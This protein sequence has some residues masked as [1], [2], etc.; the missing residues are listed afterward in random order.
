MSFLKTISLAGIQYEGDIRAL[1][2]KNGKCLVAMPQENGNTGKVVLVDIVS[3]SVLWTKTGSTANTL[4]LFGRGVVALT[5]TH[6]GVHHHEGAN[7]LS[8]GGVTIYDIDGAELWNIAGSGS[9]NLGGSGIALNSTHFAYNVDSGTSGQ[10]VVRSL[11]T[12]EITAT[13]ATPSGVSSGYLAV[14]GGSGYASL[15]LGETH[16]VAS[17]YNQVSNV[18]G[19]D[20]KGV[21]YVWDLAGNL[22]NTFFS[23]STSA[24]MGG[25]HFAS[26]G[27]AVEND[28][29][30]TSQWRQDVGANMPSTTT[31]DAIH[32]YS[33]SA[34]SH[35]HTA[36][37]SDSDST[38]T[39]QTW[40]SLV[41][42]NEGVAGATFDD[43]SPYQVQTFILGLREAEP[44][45][46]L[47]A[48]SIATTA[49]VA[50]AANSGPQG[51]QGDIGLQGATG[52]Q[53][54]AGSDGAQGPIGLQGA[55]GPQGAQ[56]ANVSSIDELTDVD[57]TT[58]APTANQVLVWDN[59]NSKFVPGDAASGGSSV[60]VSDSAPSNPSSGDL[61][62]NSTNMKLYAYYVDGSSNQWVEVSASSGGGITFS[63]ATSDVTM[64]S[65][66]TYILDTST[67][68][69]A[70]LPASAVLGDKIGIIDGTGGASSNNITVARNS[71]KIQG[72]SENMT[73]AK[74][75]AAFELVYYNA[76]NGW[77]LTSV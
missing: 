60:T 67:A 39:N 61:W 33:I 42:Y 14:A 3:E 53:G 43:R 65:G 37:F 29:V 68:I 46:Y 30:V 70:T 22:T 12:G 47:P 13:L 17:D 72:L 34:N 62:L 31:S 71:H 2:V 15:D 23:P 36:T 10:I 9:Q 50:A 11:A 49:F 20:Y 55:T 66:Y 7:G 56:G 75:R 27:V 16:I 54:T 64:L 6:A 59:A 38:T 77:L 18:D 51:A 5:D 1:S 26:S 76:T 48:S 21:I 45:S 28:V 69:T 32:F 40:G 57:V 74:N 4:S 8:H 73:V 24:N 41:K 63:A 58:T 44:E 52:L 25:T 35:T 19:V